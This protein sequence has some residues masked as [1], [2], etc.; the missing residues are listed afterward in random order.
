MVHRRFAAISGVV[1]TSALVTPGVGSFAQSAEP[2]TI[3]ITARRFAF[4]PAEIRAAVG[5]R[6]QLVI[7]SADGVHGLEIK[8]LKVKQEVP[9]GGNAAVVEF[10]ATEAGRFPI[11]CSEYC[12]DGHERMTGMLVVSASGDDTSR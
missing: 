9:R 12:G 7:R 3:E 11:L 10:T 5:E 1:L 6:L 8:R 2:R 4:E